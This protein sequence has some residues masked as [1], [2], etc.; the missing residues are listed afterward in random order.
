[1]KFNLCLIATIALA[2][3]SQEKGT[4]PLEYPES[5]NAETKDNYFGVEV[6]D[7]YRWLEEEE[8]ADTKNWVE[9]QNKVTF[10]YLEKIPFRE[11]IKNRL[12]DLWNYPKVFAPFKAGD[13]YLC[14]KNDGLQNQS[15]LYIRE[16]LDGEEKVFLDPNTF[17]TDGTIA[18]SSQ[19]ASNDGRYLAYS[20]SRSGSDWNEIIVK[21]FSSGKILDDTVK[22]VKFSTIA[23]HKD[24]YFYSA[25]ER[26]E[27]NVYSAKNEYHKIFYH[28]LNTNQNNDLL[29]YEDKEH[30]LRNFYAETTEDDRYLVIMGSEGTSGNSVVL[31]DLQTNR[32][33]SVIDDFKNDHYFAGSYNGYLYF[34]TNL[35]A[36]NKRVVRFKPGSPASGK[37][38]TVLPEQDYLIESADIAGDALPSLTSKTLQQ[39]FGILLPMGK[40]EKKLRCLNR[41]M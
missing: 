28:Q 13:F 22:G 4:E 17:S 34:L 11:K 26:P 12:S 5:R 16:G 41:A 36:G 23:W 10:A 9:E 29:V 35:D 20:I 3:C 21:E 2:S 33:I 6:A 39:G 1:M 7:P 30:P 31:K 14:Y 32:F 18:I 38:E 15:V 40:M 27:K 8:S 25:Y 24:G 37:W 19:N